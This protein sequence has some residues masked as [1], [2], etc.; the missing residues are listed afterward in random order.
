MPCVQDEEKLLCRV[1]TSHDL[2]DGVQLQHSPGW[3][4]LLTILQESGEQPSSSS[5]FRPVAKR[6]R[7]E[8]SNT[9]RPLDKRRREEPPPSLRPR[10]YDATD[11]TVDQLAKQIRRSSLG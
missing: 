9:L 3:A 4:T 11:E 10:A 8:S 2:S 7:E 1:A 6:R 5:T